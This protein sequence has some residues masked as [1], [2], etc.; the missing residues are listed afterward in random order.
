[1]IM[2][3]LALAAL[4]PADRWI[5]VGGSTNHYEEYV[6]SESIKR[7][8]DKV[9]LWT[10]R[11]FAD[12]QGTV[13]HELELDC[14]MRTETILAYI[15]DDGRS[16]SHNSVRPHRGASLIPSDSVAERIFNVACR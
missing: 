2:T 1:M 5:H 15:R 12:D 8:G 13:W 10:R 4:T 16:V 9:A 14:R 6:D 3:A 11:N 7:S